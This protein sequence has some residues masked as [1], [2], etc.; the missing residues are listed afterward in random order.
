MKNS[1]G[2]KIIAFNGSPVKDSNTDILTKQVLAGAQRAGFIGQQIYL[3][4]FQI[5]P[6][7]SCGESPGEDLCLLKDELFPYLHQSAQSDI[8]V[9]SS[10]IYFDTVS[11]QTKL[12]IDRCNCFKPLEGYDSGDFKFVDLN[13]K[14]RLGILILVGGEREKFEHAVTVIKGFFIWTQVKF[15]GQILYPHSDYRKGVVSEND[16]ILQ[17]AYQLGYETAQKIKN[18]SKPSI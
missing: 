3:N 9:I 15:A 16:Q 10:P 6:C 7:Q 13:L 1:A 14:P 8:V 18:N 2:N 4:D 5:T 17:N 11:A 12:L